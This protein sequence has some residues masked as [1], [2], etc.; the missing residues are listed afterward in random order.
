MARKPAVTRHITYTQAVCRCVDTTNGQIFGK[1]V[2]LQ[3]IV[4]D[5]RKQLEKC[6]LVLDKGNIHVLQVEEV[7]YLQS[8]ASQTEIEFLENAQILNTVELNIGKK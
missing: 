2:K 7:K 8:F 5:K 4:K 6:R 1:I 3:R